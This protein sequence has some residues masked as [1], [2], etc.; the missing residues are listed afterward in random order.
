VASSFA[1]RA[2]RAF[3]DFFRKGLRRGRKKASGAGIPKSL[4]R[5]EIENIYRFWIISPLAARRPRRRRNSFAR[6]HFRRATATAVD[7]S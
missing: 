7:I 6:Q 1:D 3:F 2:A 5:K 4:R